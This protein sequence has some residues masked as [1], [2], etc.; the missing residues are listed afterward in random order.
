VSIHKAEIRELILIASSL[1]TAAGASGPLEAAPLV[2]NATQI[3]SQ[4]PTIVGVACGQ[5]CHAI[6]TGLESQPIVIADIGGENLVE[7]VS[8][9]DGIS[10][11][12]GIACPPA[13]ANQTC[14]AVGELVGKN[15][16]TVGEVVQIT[17][18][19]SG[20]TV[21][22]PVPL[23]G[24]ASLA[25]IACPSETA[26]YA[27]GDAAGSD[28]PVLVN[29]DTLKLS[30]SKVVPVPP[31]NCGTG[32]TSIGISLQGIACPNTS[33]CTA[34]GDDTIGSNSAGF[35]AVGILLRFEIPGLGNLT[36]NIVM[37]GSNL[38]LSGAGCLSNE[39]CYA[40]GQFAEVI[41]GAP[42]GAIQG[43]VVPNLNGNPGTVQ[44]DTLPGGAPF[45]AVACVPNGD[46]FAVGGPEVVPI[47]NGTLAATSAALL[48]SGSLLSSIACTPNY[49]C[50]AVGTTPFETGRT[51][52]LVASFVVRTVSEVSP[53]DGP[54][55]GGTPVTI[56]GT[57]F[58]TMPG[59]TVFDVQALD[60]QFP[61]PLTGVVCS[62]ST[63]CTGKMPEW[64][65]GGEVSVTAT[66]IGYPSL[67]NATFTYSHPP[68]RASGCP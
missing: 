53:S 23:E 16:I 51:D 10:I 13:P 7:F 57:G 43:A 62:S 29:I 63:T 17:T 42:Q 36:P 67:T 24:T 20:D 56:K 33:V 25:A 64:P 65:L 3:V 37:D 22:T 32:C 50:Y 41:Q 21:G 18:D 60:G 8:E 27:V 39:T 26:C 4:A 59:T 1:M 58:G 14:Y 55:F 2:I 9:S 46:C 38:Q 30:Q 11:L 6:G 34:I 5:T 68:C 52:G 47:L 45:S 66:V 28:D 15:S 61:V 54:W 19:S 49:F 31:L 35:P 48:P 40:V 44:T 12:K